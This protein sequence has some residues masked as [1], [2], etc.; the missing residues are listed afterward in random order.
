[1]VGNKDYGSPK[2]A[3]RLHNCQF[4]LGS[5]VALLVA[6]PFLEEVTRPVIFVM[7]L[8]GVFVAGV[9]V[10]DPGR[11]RIRLALIIAAIQAALTVVTLNNRES[12]TLYTISVSLAPIG[13]S[14][15]RREP[16]EPGTC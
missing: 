14:T 2:P 15:I 11:R 13:I 16:P 4:L 1:V 5:L 3:E 10:V 9:Y 7:S 12:D 6:F 8:T